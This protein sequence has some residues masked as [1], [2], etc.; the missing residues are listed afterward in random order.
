MSAAATR[1]K[2]AGAVDSIAALAPMPWL[3]RQ[4][5]Q[6]LQQKG[7]ALLLQGASG[8]GQFELGLDL[9]KAWLC[10]SRQEGQPYAHACGHCAGCHAVHVH[11]H[12]DLLVLLPEWQQLELGWLAPDNDAAGEGSSKRKPSKDIRIDAMRQMI[13]FSQRTDSR[14][15]GKVVIVYPAENMNHITANALLKTLEEPP[16]G[17]RFILA[18]D[19]ADRLLPTIRSRCHTWVLQ[20]P[21]DDEA[22]QWL[23]DCGVHAHEAQAYLTMAGGRPA[24]ALALARS[25]MKFQDWSDLPLAVASGHAGVLA[26]LTPAAAVRVLQK[27]CHDMLC[28]VWGA[29]PRYFSGQV[30]Q[31]ILPTAAGHA[32][33]HPVVAE[34]LGLWF[35]ALS[36]ASRTSEHPFAPELMLTALVEQARSALSFKQ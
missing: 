16:G 28:M 36:D 4:E 31:K 8:L 13:T 33:V 21:Q 27:L 7:H 29:P 9:A 14:G 11:T 25:G 12:P 22:Q 1:S 23:Q 3:A 30:L 15:R 17:T 19:A 24:D 20:W 6:L 26:T 35:Q 5:T 34:R 2:D 18:T 32:R 10:E